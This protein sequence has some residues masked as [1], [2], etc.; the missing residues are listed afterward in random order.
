MS[1]PD[2]KLDAIGALD[3]FQLLLYASK[4]TRLSACDLAVLGELTDRYT[5]KDYGPYKA[6]FTRP[7][8]YTHL[9]RETGY[10]RT[11]V[12]ESLARLQEHG[13]IRIA[14]DGCGTRGNDYVLNFNWSRTVAAAI[15]KEVDARKVA[16]K[17]RHR[18]SVPE[19]RHSKD[20]Q[21]V[22]RSSAPLRDIVCR[23]SDTLTDLVCR[24]SGTQT[25]VGPTGP[26]VGADMS[27]GTDRV[28]PPV[29]TKRIV[30]TSV[31][32]EDGIKWL[33]V[34]FDTGLSDFIMIESDDASDQQEGWER[35]NRLTSSAGL[36]DIEDASELI[37][38]TVRMQGDR[39][40]SPYEE[41]AN[42]NSVD[43]QKAA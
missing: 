13:Y 35:L 41:A 20:N 32:E 31:E 43:N 10:A 38:H 7:T 8:G 37:G 42:D 23:S 34:D 18:A 19:N 25:Y 4:D 30:A 14:H 17:R 24:L 22:C 16:K 26:Y 36:G 29:V 9:V 5:K 33:A 2:K 1:K 6:G 11:S 39:Y 12:R 15:A 3:Q 27:A 28:P 40:L 21:L